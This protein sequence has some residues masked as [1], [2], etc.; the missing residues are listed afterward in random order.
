MC[1]H[2]CGLCAL[3]NRYCY[4][5]GWVERIWG[6]L[7]AKPPEQYSGKGKW[8]PIVMFFFESRSHY[9]DKASLEFKELHLP[10]PKNDPLNKHVIYQYANQA[11]RS[12]ECSSCLT[13]SLQSWG[14]TQ[15]ICRWRGRGITGSVPIPHPK[16]LPPPPH[17]SCLWTAQLVQS[18]TGLNSSDLGLRHHAWLPVPFCLLLYNSWDQ[19]TDRNNHK[20]DLFHQNVQSILAGT[21]VSGL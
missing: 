7:W 14:A 4:C 11:L 5:E 10:L 9:V 3:K 18:S 17:P 15:V 12:E 16:G 8:T 20:K 1:V 19:I 13:G 21:S 2:V 6:S